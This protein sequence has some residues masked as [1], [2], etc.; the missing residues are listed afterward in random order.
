M[1]F[2]I[3]KN[4]LLN[5]LINVSRAIS[6]RNIIPILN[7]IKFELNDEGLYLTASDSD[8]T[9]KSYISKDNIEKIE[10]E[11]IIIIQSKYLLD[12]IKKMP[13]DVVNFEVVDDNKVIIFSDNSEYNLNCLNSLDYPEIQLEDNTTHI[14]ITSSALKKVISQTL[15]ATSVQ[16][17]RPLLTGLNI[18]INGDVLECTAT[19]SYRLAKKIIS[20]EKPYEETVNIVVPGKT[21]GDLDKIL[22]D[23]DDNVEIHIFSKKIMFKYNNIVFQTNLLNG[24]Y[25]NTSNFIPTEFMHVV[26]ANLNDY[27]SSL[28]RAALLTQSKEKNIVKMELN[29]NELILSSFASEIGKV[30]DKISVERNINDPM[31]I[32]FSSK[33]M[34]D[35]LKTFDTEKILIKMNGDSKPI[36]ITST[37]DDLLIQLILPIKTY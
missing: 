29:N 5:E 35:A 31:S 34:M 8:L 33:Y 13:G 24:E 32:S 28:D 3:N 27:Y 1:K 7:G 16:E 36:I 12:I 20:L 2:S 21:M 25:P 6:T 10:K 4:K 9:I 17:S 19:D 23:K 15:F 18:K 30:E 14:D 11:G 37:E 22:E 26:T